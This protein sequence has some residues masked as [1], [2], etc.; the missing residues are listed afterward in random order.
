MIINADPAGIEQAAEALLAGR[1][2]AFPT[3]TLYGLGVDALS[4]EALEALQQIKS[5]R[6]PRQP[7]PVIISS[8]EMLQDCLVQE[9]PPLARVLMD[10]HWPGPL[11]VVLPGRRTLPRSLVN[12]RGGV[13]VRVPGDPVALALV[14]RVGR[15]ITATS[16]NRSN[17][18]PAMEAHQAELPGVALVLNDGRR[19]EVAS[20]VVEVSDKI[21]V[22][23]QGAIKIEAR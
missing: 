1:V 17:Q 20:T 15:P 4:A 23:R 8:L 14:Q 13:G 6:T 3:E 9:I 2:I 11:T 10:R 18:P 5:R 16:A 7:F 22:L 19:G 12:E 21:V